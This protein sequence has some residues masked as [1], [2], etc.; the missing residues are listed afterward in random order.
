[1][2]LGQINSDFTEGKI[3]AEEELLLYTNRK[4]LKV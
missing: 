4:E 1:M 2:R 3:T